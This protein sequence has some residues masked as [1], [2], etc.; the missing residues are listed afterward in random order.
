MACALDRQAAAQA[1]TLTNE[2][3]SSQGRSTLSSSNALIAAA[4]AHACELDSTGRFS[5]DGANGSSVGDRVRSRGYRWGFVAE[6][7]LICEPTASDAV[8]GWIGSRPHRRNMRDNRADDIG[9]A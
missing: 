9:I 8:N 4:E 1:V 5:H 6:N 2:Y 7:I 3:R